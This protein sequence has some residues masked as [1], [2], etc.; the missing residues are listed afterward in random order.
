M[1]ASFKKAW[2]VEGSKETIFQG[3]EADFDVL[4][5]KKKKKAKIVENCPV[6]NVKKTRF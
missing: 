6:A 3:C 4:R 2:A 5:R 1:R